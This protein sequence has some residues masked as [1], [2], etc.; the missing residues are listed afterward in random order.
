MTLYAIATIWLAGGVVF[1]FRLWRH[2]SALVICGPRFNMEDFILSAGVIVVWPFAVTF[3][4]Y[5][6]MR[7]KQ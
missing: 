4:I 1:A 2:R 6:W 3:E 5:Q 7:G